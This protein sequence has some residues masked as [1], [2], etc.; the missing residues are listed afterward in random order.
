VSECVHDFVSMRIAATVD[1][2]QLCG[3]PEPAYTIAKLKAEL[4]EL[5]EAAAAVT[6]ALLPGKEVYIGNRCIK[7]EVSYAAAGINPILRLK[8]LQEVKK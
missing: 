7:Y 8:A 5:R 2:C 6:S 1:M 3:V 4:A